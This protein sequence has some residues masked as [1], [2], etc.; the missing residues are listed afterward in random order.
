ME[1]KT[2]K[3]V[4]TQL[5]TL[6]SIIDLYDKLINCGIAKDKVH[7]YESP[8]CYSDYSMGEEIDVRCNMKPIE[9]VDNRKYYAKSCKWSEK[10]GYIL[11]NF[12]KKDLKRYVQIGLEMEFALKSKDNKL[13]LNLLVEK[14]ALLRKSFVAEKSIVKSLIIYS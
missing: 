2:Y 11:L 1:T 12:S 10:H 13:Y 8:H 14:K 3:Q 5:E 9:K 4:K 6:N 7:Y